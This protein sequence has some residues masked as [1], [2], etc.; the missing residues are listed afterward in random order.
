MKN[1]LL[2]LIKIFF[3]KE[4]KMQYIAIKE[5]RNKTDERVYIVN[6]ISLKNKNKSVIQKIPH[7]LGTDSLI[8]KD[9]EEAKTAITRAGFSYI[10]PNGEKEIT[11]PKPQSRTSTTNKYEKLIFETIKKNINSTNSNVSASAILAITEF[12]NEETF[13]IL[14]DKI[15][16]ENEQIRKNAISGIC[17]YGQH[18][19]ERIIKSLYSGNWVCRN[20]AII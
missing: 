20:S 15:G 18:L 12:P 2:K 13:K 3:T 1:F 11:I 4:F 5:E 16:E 14:F 17:R 8:F 7:P 10:L 6:A 9:I 19:Q